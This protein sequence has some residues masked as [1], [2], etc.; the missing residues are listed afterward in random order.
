[1]SAGEFVQSVESSGLQWQPALAALQGL[2]KDPKWHTPHARVV[3]SNLWARYA[4]VAWEP[5]L[6]TPEEHLAHAR[7][8]LAA[9]YGN[10]DESWRVTLS[11][12]E[13]GK[14]RIACALPEGLI[15]HLKEL[16]SA[17]EIRVISLQPQL[18]AA[19]NEWRERLPDEGAWFVSVEDG[20]LV[21]AR[22][23][24]RD[25]D[26]V[27]CARIGPDWSVELLR[28]KTFARMA[29]SS[30]EAGRV[31]VHAPRRL[32]TLAGVD[33]E[34]L[35]WLGD[36]PLQRVSATVVRLPV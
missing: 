26:R 4:I 15:A 21:A 3:V 16:T 1:M 5:Q 9:T 32:R 25:W 8:C 35:E 23:G 28:L 22:L 24:H 20:A 27:Y 12:A 13:A 30:G 36:E 29:S 34:G 33:G 7:I 6:V 2:L 11:E 18:I 31:F 14:P 19:Y 17:H 10:M